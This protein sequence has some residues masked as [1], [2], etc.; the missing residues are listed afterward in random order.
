MLD[1]LLDLAA[2][3]VGDTA[4]EFL[5]DNT[6]KRR[7]K[8]ASKF[9][10]RGRSLPRPVRTK[11]PVPHSRTGRRESSLPGGRSGMARTPGTGR[12]KS[13]PGR[14]ER[15]LCLIWIYCSKK[16]P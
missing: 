16:L 13:P 7:E 11:L 4:A 6:R 9:A 14:A 15:H 1:D 10:D 8:A 12:R 5:G 2:D 3:L